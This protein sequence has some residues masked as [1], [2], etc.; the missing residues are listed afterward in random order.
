MNN[1]QPDDIEKSSCGKSRLKKILSQPGI[2]DA[3]AAVQDYALEKAVFKTIDEGAK[4]EFG[5]ELKAILESDDKDSID[6][7]L[8]YEQVDLAISENYEDFLITFAV[9]A[10]PIIAKLWG[11]SESAGK[12]ISLATYDKREWEAK[13]EDFYTRPVMYSLMLQRLLTSASAPFIKL[14]SYAVKF[15]R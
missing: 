3:I 12:L 7:F 10:G 13:V 8:E 1:E 14:L 2:E 6:C 11:L 4:E 15:S 9:E 5:D